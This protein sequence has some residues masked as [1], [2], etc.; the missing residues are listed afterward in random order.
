MLCTTKY[1]KYRAAWQCLPCL[2]AH[3]YV[4]CRCWPAVSDASPL[5]PPLSLPPSCHLSILVRPVEARAPVPVVTPLEPAVLPAAS[6][7][8]TAS[9]GISAAQRGADVA[10]LRLVA[11]GCRGARTGWRA[12]VE[13][14]AC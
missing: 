14:K 9:G 7:P 1:E 5:P 10:W 6:S 11:R 2:R 8:A 4:A 12:P 3:E 13:A